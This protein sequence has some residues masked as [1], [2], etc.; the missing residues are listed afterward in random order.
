MPKHNIEEE[1]RN[2]EFPDRGTAVTRIINV[3]NNG[4]LKGWGDTVPADA[5]TG[6]ATGA[7]FHHLNG[8]GVGDVLFVNIGDTTSANFD[9]L[10]TGETGLEA[11]LALTTTGN[12][13]SKIGLEDSGTFTAAAEVEAALAELYQHLKSVQ[14]HVSLN[15][16]DFRE[17]VNFD[18]G[19]IAANAGILASDTTPVL[20]AINVATDGAQRILWASSDSTEISIQETL[21]PD[22]DPTADV[23][24][25]FRAAMGGATDTPTIALTSFFNEGDT[26]VVD[27]SGAV[28]GTSFVE[29]TATI[30][31]ADI[32]AGAQTITFRLVPGAHTT[33]TLAISSVW[34]E[35]KKNILTA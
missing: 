27:A 35:F 31:A 7:I 14:G 20:D 3:A 26:A 24:L 30:A 22:L 15:L 6:W 19:D 4:R 21:P 10:S 5:A 11:E 1:L 12:G 32:P 34:L 13:A 23:V 33:D 2:G 16:R 17:T 25:H 9:A 18:V 8:S 29:Y 28:T